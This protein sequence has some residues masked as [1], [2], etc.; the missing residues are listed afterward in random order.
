VKRTFDVILSFIGIV[1]SLPLWLLIAILIYLQDR[2]RIFIVQERVGLHGKIFHAYK[3]RSMIKGAENLPHVQAHESDPRITPIG[4]L[5]RATAMDELPQLFN[6]LKGDMSFVGPRALLPSEIELKGNTNDQ[7]M[8]S[9]L[10]EK[11][12]RVVPGLTG[13]AQIFAPRDIPRRKKFRYDLLYIRKQSFLLD[14]K[15]IF[16]SF[17]ITFTGNWESRGDK[18]RVANRKTNV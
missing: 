1:V 12:C 6:I 5:L 13:I 10:F 3:F 9:E 16:L 2:G 17:W 11:R 7:E 18:L 4:R 15:L 14:L 8:T